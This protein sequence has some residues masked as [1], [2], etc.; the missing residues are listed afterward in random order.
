M[1]NLSYKYTSIILMYDLFLKSDYDFGIFLRIFNKFFILKMINRVH[2]IYSLLYLFER[3]SDD[4]IDDSL[5]YLLTSS[6]GQAYHVIEEPLI[7]G[8][9]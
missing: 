1:S 2:C 9:I 5:H 6:V 4:F 3:F 8:S 7:S